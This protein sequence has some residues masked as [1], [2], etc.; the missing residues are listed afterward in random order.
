MP[1]RGGSRLNC[2][3]NHACHSIVPL[4]SP[5]GG[6]RGLQAPGPLRG[7]QTRGWDLW[8]THAPS[9]CL[10]VSLSLSLSHCLCVSPSLCLTI[11]VSRCLCLSLSCCLCLTVSYCLFHC[12][13]LS[14]SLYLAVSVSSCLCIFISGSLHS[15]SDHIF[16]LGAS[17]TQ[18]PCRVL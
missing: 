13:C 15:L 9:L 14:L 8:H 18:S 16:P 3:D 5:V 10:C 1:P 6:A 12:L 7:P 4:I 11:S 2:Q 17:Q